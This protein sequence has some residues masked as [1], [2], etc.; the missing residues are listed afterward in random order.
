M[1]LQNNNT[2]DIYEN[3]NIIPELPVGSYELMYGAFGRIYLE[4]VDDII[5]P[6]KIYGNDTEFIK[7]VLHT[8]EDVKENVGVGLVG[9]KGLGKSLTANIIAKRSNLPV[10]SITGKNNSSTMFEFLNRIEQDF[11]LFIDEFEKKIYQE[12]KEKFSQE[13]F[14]SFLD[15]G[16][17]RKNKVVFI[18][19]VNNE[20]SI[21]QFLL[22]RP[23]RLRYFKRYDQLCKNVIREVIDDLLVNKDFTQ[24]LL[25]ELPY[26]DVNLDV[27]IKIIQEINLHNSPYSSFKEFFNFKEEAGLFQ[28]STEEDGEEKVLKTFTD[29]MGGHVFIANIDKY[30][31]FTSQYIGSEGEYSGFKVELETEKE[32]PLMLKVKKVTTK[33]L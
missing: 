17:E 26:E 24:D 31:Y 1:I 2:Y 21:N 7:H 11:V 27:L 18:I 15:G 16:I 22:N 4:K 20:R 9:G 29:F 33:L 5:L 3:M 25:D 6:E 30:R 14:L 12:N 10:I 32:Y 13:D 23:S 19:T 8:I 28:I